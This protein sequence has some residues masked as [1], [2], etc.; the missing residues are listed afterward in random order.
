VKNT[1]WSQRDDIAEEFYGLAEQVDEF[2]QNLLTLWSDGGYT[3]KWIAST[4][5]DFRERIRQAVAGNITETQFQFYARKCCK[6]LINN[7]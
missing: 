2:N 3:M 7:L 6:S 1:K 4:Y 5:V